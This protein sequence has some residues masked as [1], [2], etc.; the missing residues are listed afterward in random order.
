MDL[1]LNLVQ[2][3]FSVAWHQYSVKSCACV[4]DGGMKSEMALILGRKWACAENNL[5]LFSSS[6]AEQSGVEQSR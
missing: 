5:L 2:A 4:E 1:S 6:R 3:F